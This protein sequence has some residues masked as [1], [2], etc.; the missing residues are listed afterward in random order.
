MLGFNKWF[1]IFLFLSL[2]VWY[3][4]GNWIMASQ[5]MLGFIVVRVIWSFLTKK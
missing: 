1:V 2:A 5:M 4:T 3:G